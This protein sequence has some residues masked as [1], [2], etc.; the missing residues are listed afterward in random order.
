MAEIKQIASQLKI[1]RRMCLK[2]ASLLVLGGYGLYRYWRYT[3]IS[4]DATIAANFCPKEVQA[5]KACNYGQLE[6]CK[7]QLYNLHN[8]VKLQ[9]ANNDLN[10]NDL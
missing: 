10:Y 4:R 5:F 7:M 6:D 9:T 8:C 3:T 1:S 2:S